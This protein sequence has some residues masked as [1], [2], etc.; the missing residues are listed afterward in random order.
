MYD[1]GIDYC[2]PQGAWFSKYIPHKIAGVCINRICYQ[3]DMGWAD[4]RHTH[5]D[6]MFRRQLMR[7]FRNAGHPIIGAIVS[8]IYYSAVR[9][10]RFVK[11]IGG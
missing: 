5:A 7:E 4:G 11:W 2:G 1:P 9:V 6:R 8:G 10:G 3:H